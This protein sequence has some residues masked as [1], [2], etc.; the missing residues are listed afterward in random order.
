M[1][2]STTTSRIAKRF[3]DFTSIKVIADAGFDAVDYSM[4]CMNEEENCILNTDAYKEHILKVKEYETISLEELL[5]KNT[6]N[7]N[8]LFVMMKIQIN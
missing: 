1:K 7:E 8:S 4:F 3:D 6:N 5:E 2:V